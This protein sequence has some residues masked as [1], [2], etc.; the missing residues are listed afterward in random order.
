MNQDLLKR[1]IKAFLHDPPEKAIILMQ[2]G[3]KHEEQAK[4]LLRELIQ[5]DDIEEVKKADV[6]ASSADRINLPY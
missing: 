3:N 5:E 4:K 1:K 2:T 6:E